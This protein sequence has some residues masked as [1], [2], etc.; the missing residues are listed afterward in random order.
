MP[1]G[2]DDVV[3]VIRWQLE[4]IESVATDL[5]GDAWASGVYES[6]W[7][8]KQLLCHLAAGGGFGEFMIRIGKSPPPNVE[9]IEFDQ[10]AWNARE[11]ATREGKSVAELLDELRVGSERSIAAVESAPD[12][13]LAGHFRAPWGMEGSL[14]QVIIESIEDH[15][16][17]HVAQLRE[18]LVTG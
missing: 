11:V 4:E 7:N 6:G 18:A 13:L 16:G 14:A 3:R 8:A 5:S 10:D 12:E 17:T 15:V 1:A 9:G 2:K